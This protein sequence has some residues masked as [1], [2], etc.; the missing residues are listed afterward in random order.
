MQAAKERSE[1]LLYHILPRNIVNSLD[2]GEKDISF[3]VPS[4]TVIFI[5]I[6]KFSEHSQAHSPMKIMGNLSTIFFRFDSI[7]EKFDTIT[8]IKL[9]GDIYMAAGGIFNEEGNFSLHAQQVVQFGLECIAALEELN[10]ILNANLQ[11][12]VG[13]NTGPL[14]AGVLGIDKPTFDIIG[15]AINVASRLQ[16]TDIP[17]NVQISEITYELIKEMK[18]NIEERDEIV[19]K[20]KGKQKAYLVNNIPNLSSSNLTLSFSNLTASISTSN[21]H[22]HHQ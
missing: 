15:D 10:Q 22:S 18:W 16:S 20:G 5:N 14:I 13:V 2:Q 6:V 8:K 17:G 12:R 4:A 9:I 7:C 21:I 11:V 19:L 1:E 3:F